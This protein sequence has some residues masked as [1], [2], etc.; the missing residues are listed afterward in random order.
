MKLINKLIEAE[1]MRKKVS[2]ALKEYRQRNHLTQ[3]QLAE[4]L[5]VS[6]SHIS[7]LEKGKAILNMEQ[8][9]KCFHLGIK[10]DKALTVER[11]LFD[12]A[13]VKEAIQKIKDRKRLAKQNRLPKQ[14][15]QPLPEPKPFKSE[16][17]ELK[18][19]IA[20]LTQRVSALSEGAPIECDA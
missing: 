10:I 11:N 16:L 18:D 7:H 20:S 5:G 19:Q 9:L 6:D 14:D 4:L 2:L 12:Q 13:H 15:T 1:E 17:D 8:I 3:S